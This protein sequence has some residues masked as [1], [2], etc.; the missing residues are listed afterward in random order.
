[1]P[2]DKPGIGKVEAGPSIVHDKGEI[3]KEDIASVLVIALDTKEVFNKTFHVTSGEILI[4]EALQ[5]L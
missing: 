1:M 3:P 5:R 4:D 2:V